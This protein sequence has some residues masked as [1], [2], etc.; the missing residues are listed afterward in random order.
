MNESVTATQ[1]LGDDHRRVRELYRRREEEP[2]GGDPDH[3]AEGLV[4]ELEIHSWLEERRVYPV[5]SQAC[6]DDGYAG[7]FQKAHGEIKRL[8]SEFRLAQLAGG[9]GSPRGRALLARIMDAFLKHAAEEEEHAFP[10]LAADAA[11]NKE[12]GAELIKAR[13]KMD[14]FP[15]IAQSIELAVPVRVA[16]DQWIRFE[17]FPHFLG[18]V[19]EVRQLGATRVVWRANVGGKAVQWTSEIHEQIPD[20]RIAWTSVDGALNAGSVSFQPLNG[21]TT[22]MLVELTYEPQGLLE[23]LGAMVAVLSRLI[24]TSLRNYKDYIERTRGE[25]GAWRGQAK[26]SPL[27]PLHANRGGA[28]PGPGW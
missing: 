26:G 28:R 3:L 12:L 21:G 22:R 7:A 18:N 20:A 14:L 4:K 19:K 16:Y 24:S 6:R 10:V 5:L 25:T 27:D 8:I 9:S 11:S 2:M 13:G 15:P 1:V 17:D 23:N